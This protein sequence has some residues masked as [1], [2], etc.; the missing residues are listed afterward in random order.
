MTRDPRLK[1]L[2][3]LFFFT[4]FAMS[5]LCQSNSGRSFRITSTYSMFPDSLRDA[6][7]RVYDNKTYTAK[8]H[9]SDSSVYLF[10]PAWFDRSK[11]FHFIFWFHGWGNNIDSALVEYKLQE[12]F[13]AAHL[14]AIFVFPEGPRNS[15][16]SYGGKFEQAGDFNLFMK[17]LLQFLSKEKIITSTSRPVDL[18]Y[19]G[20]SGAYRVMAYLLLTSSYPCRGILLFDALY[21]Q[22]EK[23]VMYLQ[24]HSSC[25]MINIYTNNGGTMENSKDMMVDMN[26][27]KWR[28]IQKEDEDITAAD[29][30]NNRFVFIHT[31][32]QHNEVV[33]NHNNF[34]R[35]LESFK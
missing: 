22:Q 19:A 24:Q 6:E 34:Q 5:S 10:V 8:E 1:A 30:K 27:W 20:H 31:N 2:G 14:N 21:S 28:Y 11:P 33:A 7:P 3:L 26:A 4:G 16:D 12:Q 18:V 32:V 17:D 15:P 25:K 13:D 29:L 9:Y 35:F 23:F